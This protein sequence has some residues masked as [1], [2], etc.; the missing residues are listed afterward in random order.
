VKEPLTQR[1]TSTVERV[2][3]ATLC[4]DLSP[5]TSPP[6]PAY[7]EAVVEVADDFPASVASPG[8]CVEVDGS[9]R[10]GAHRRAEAPAT[11][12]SWLNCAHDEALE[13][14]VHA[15]TRHGLP[16]PLAEPRDAA[17]VILTATP[18]RSARA[19][20]EVCGLSHTTVA[21]LRA[22]SLLPGG[23]RPPVACVGG[24]ERRRV[25]A[26][27]SSLPPPGTDKRRAADRR[28]RY[29]PG[30]GR[31]LEFDPA[32]PWLLYDRAPQ[33]LAET[34]AFLES[35]DETKVTE[36]HWAAVV[37]TSSSRRLS[38]LADGAHRRAG[39]WSDRPQ[40]WTVLHDRS[41]RCKHRAFAKEGP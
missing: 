3:A 16:S 8:S 7:V 10:A 34:G 25:L 15:N 36:E 32:G 17:V 19:I 40:R 18:G 20:A 11:A 33:A 2:L 23:G 6:G 35:L 5:R 4:V 26:M 9:H 29:P 39:A 37:P 28:A 38:E 24:D 30:N 21:K 27:A 1:A 22:G 13:A 12:V 14:V 31:A 41:P